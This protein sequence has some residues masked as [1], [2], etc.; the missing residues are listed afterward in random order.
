MQPTYVEATR[1][2]SFVSRKCIALLLVFAATAFVLI[3]AEQTASDAWK[4]IAEVTVG[5]NAKLDPRRQE[6]DAPWRV[7][8]QFGHPRSDSVS[9][10]SELARKQ[11]ITG[12]EF[13]KDGIPTFIH[14]T[15]GVGSGFFICLIEK[16]ASTVIK[17]ALN[18]TFGLGEGTSFHQMPN[19]NLRLTADELANLFGKSVNRVPRFVVTRNP[20]TRLLSGYNAKYRKDSDKSKEQV[21]PFPGTI[22]NFTF[23]MLIKSMHEEWRAKG[24]AYL[25]TLN[26]HFRPVHMSHCGFSHGLTYDFLLPLEKLQ[27]W[28][29]DFSKYTNLSAKS[30]KI[31]KRTD[32]EGFDHH[33]YYTDSMLYDA[34]S[35]EM[36]KM[37][38]EMFRE[39]FKQLGY[40]PILRR[41]LT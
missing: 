28:A 26:P 22:P 14:E 34:Y 18:V 25:A 38:L 20:F 9:S 5:V 30:L 33:N 16:C 32:P 37:T 36:K 7:L 12:K 39:D 8:R 31:L 10:Y 1:S 23:A 6:S 15:G 2:I 11:D 40:S 3:F 4:S 29:D 17:H 41:T 13:F 21:R 24:D 27:T 35:E 19:P